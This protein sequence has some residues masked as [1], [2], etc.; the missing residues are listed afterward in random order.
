MRGRWGGAENG[1][2]SRCGVRVAAVAA[3]SA[4]L[5]DGA[6]TWVGI[7]R[8]H[9][10][11]VGVLAWLVVRQWGIIPALIALKGG[12]ALLILGMAVVGTDGEPRWWRAKSNQRWIVIVGLL[13]ATVWF[14][15][16]A[17]H[18]A[19]GMWMAQQMTRQ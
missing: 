10:R 8:L 18:N 19:A 2:R 17:L 14:G 5:L 13:A 11:E 9:G 12:G 6:T 1:G 4:N 3:L 16:L 7:T 15:Y